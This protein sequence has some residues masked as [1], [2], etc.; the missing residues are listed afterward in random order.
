M[1]TLCLA[2][3]LLLLTGSGYGEGNGPFGQTSRDGA[4]LQADKDGARP[5]LRGAIAP[6]PDRSYRVIRDIRYGDESNGVR[7]RLDLYLPERDA[8]KTPVLVAIHGGGLKRGS[9]EMFGPKAV[10]LAKRGYA[11]AAINYRLS[12]EH[13]LPTQTYDAKAAV[14]WVRAHASKYRLDP[15]KIGVIGG[16]AGAT[17][18]AAVGTS[19]DVK[20]LEGN[21]GGHSGVSTRVQAA[22]ALAGVYR[23]FPWLVGRRRFESG[24]MELATK[25]AP[26][27]YVSA[28][29]PP[30]LLLI[31]DKDPTP[32]G[33]A[34]HQ[35]FCKALKDRGVDSELVI[36]AGAG[37]GKCFDLEFE[38]IMAF[39]DETLLRSDPDKARAQSEAR[40]S[41]QAEV[42]NAGFNVPLQIEGNERGPA[43]PSKLGVGFLWTRRSQKVA[44]R[45]TTNKDFV[46]L[47]LGPGNI[48]VIVQ[49]KPPVRVLCICQAL[50]RTPERPFPGV[51]ETVVMLRG[52]NIGPGRV[53]VAYN[54]ERAPGTT[55]E[56]LDNLLE[57]VKQGHKMVREYGADFLVGPGLR[58]MGKR[59]HLYPKLAKH[60]EMWLIQSQRLQI[61]AAT[62]KGISPQ[63]Y[64]KKVKRIVD[65]LRSG[66]PEIR[67][68]VQIIA[69]RDSA[70]QRFN[71]DEI[72]AYARAVEDLVDSVR[73]YGGS[74]ELLNGVLDQLRGP[75]RN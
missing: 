40:L 54:P 30:F 48:N 50:T 47:I 22:V 43:S 68:V 58:E 32:G 13:Y 31:G 4:S 33:I 67:I 44:S 36:V 45:L 3:M 55:K 72:T 10:K 42:S 19:G 21:V 16:S 62:R 75:V 7:H 65:S 52:A 17:I 25:C 57:S 59:E 18:A 64:R 56:E 53:V 5:T 20:E 14:K 63:E 71:A 37:H 74:P 61:D 73:I 70:H 28:D 66:N 51:K 15:D 2:A 29:D 12:P 27:T 23:P 41:R 6:S 39:L 11:V 69:G 8:E 38:K 46:D 34:D 60:C 35:R 24:G 9:K 1:K 49:V 26:I